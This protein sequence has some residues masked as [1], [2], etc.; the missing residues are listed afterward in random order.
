MKKYFFLITFI[1]GSL[2]IFSQDDTTTYY[3]IRHAEKDRTDKTDRN[4]HLTN[5]GIKRAA[6]WSDVL[7]SANINMVYSTNYNRTKETATPTALK[8][9]LSVLLY[10]PSKLYDDDF[11]LKT[12]G[13]NV[14]IVGHSNTTPSFA[15]KILGKDLFKQINESAPDSNSNLYIITVTKNGATSIHLKVNN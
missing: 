2:S 10:D 12:K 7:S 13:K 14:L 1:L 5:K 3:L 11:K 4:P 6:F 8:N 15:N 9:K